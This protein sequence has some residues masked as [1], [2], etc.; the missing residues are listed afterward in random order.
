MN[1]AKFGAPRTFSNF[2]VS[3]LCIFGQIG[4]SSA[5]LV[6]CWAFGETY[7]FPPP[8]HGPIWDKI[9]AFTDKYFITT[10]SKGFPPVFWPKRPPHGIHFVIGPPLRV[11]QMAEPTNE[12]I[13]KWHAKYVEETR[14]LF[15][16]FKDEFDPDRETELEIVE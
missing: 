15:D 13:D 3:Y 10:I 2:C 1:F 4:H 6:P 16:R 9:H 14:K 8:P 12:E 11:P 7:L 5:A